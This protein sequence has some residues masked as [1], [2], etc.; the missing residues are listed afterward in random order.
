MALVTKKTVK[1]LYGLDIY[2][3]I[4]ILCRSKYEQTFAHSTNIEKQLNS[5]RCFKEKHLYIHINQ[6]ECSIFHIYFLI[7]KTNIMYVLTLPSDK[8]NIS[9]VPNHTK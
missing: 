9:I 8:I 4:I 1:P 2:I 7:K 6:Y 3:N 5:Y